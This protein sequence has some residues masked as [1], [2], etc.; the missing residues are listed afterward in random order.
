MKAYSA[1]LRARVVAAVEGGMARAAVARVYAV[2]EPTITRWRR[3]KR[4]TGGLAPRPIPGA[5]PTTTAGLAAALPAWL[6]EHADATLAE[7]C[8]WW[9]DRS[10]RVD[11]EPGADP[12]R[13][14]AQKN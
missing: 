4:E 12:A 11:D 5:A 9:R 2:S 14:D 1:D 13:V 6:A 10:E 7:H 8:A 3:L